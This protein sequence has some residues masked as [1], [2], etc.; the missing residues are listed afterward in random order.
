VAMLPVGYPAEEPEPAPRR[1]LADLVH[2]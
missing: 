2:D 1:W